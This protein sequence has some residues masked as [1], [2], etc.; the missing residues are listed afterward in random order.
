MTRAGD[1]LV[2]VGQRGH[3]VVSSDGGATWKQAQVPV[4]SDLVAV[5]F[6]DA[7][8]GWAVGH[9]GVILHTADGG[10]YWELQLD[11]RKAND[12]LVAG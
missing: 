8:Q 12:L 1:R 10:E 7:K 2:A 6:V 11:G 3:V 5:Y 4:S 9:D